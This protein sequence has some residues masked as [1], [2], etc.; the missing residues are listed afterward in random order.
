MK[1]TLL[2]FLTFLLVF[3]CTSVAVFAEDS[4]VEASV[5][6]SVESSV[7][8]SFEPISTPADSYAKLNEDMNKFYDVENLEISSITV[9][10]DEEP[11]M[12]IYGKL[13]NEDETKEDTPWSKK[14]ALT[15]EK[16]LELFHI[17]ESVIVYE[18]KADKPMATE[19]AAAVYKIVEDSK[20]NLDVD[21]AFNP[22]DFTRNINYMGLGM[23]GIFVVVGVVI[24]LTFILNKATGGKE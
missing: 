10:A 8:E 21:L 24:I 3:C 14:F 5:E 16:Y 1:K 4:S 13:L 20:T 2:V 15:E 22:A 23:L 12:V 11:Y 6:T 7:P 18:K 9:V 17:N 19:T